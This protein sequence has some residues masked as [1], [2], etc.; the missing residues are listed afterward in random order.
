MCTNYLITSPPPTTNGDL[1]LGHLSG[2]YLHADIFAKAKQTLG[3]KVLHLSGTDDHQSY[4]VTKS[5]EEKRSI[6]ETIADY[7]REII[8]TLSLANINIDFF[9]DPMNN[10][11]IDFVQRFFLDLYQKGVFKEKNEWGYYCNTCDEYLFEAHIKGKCPNCTSFSGG[12]YCEACGRPNNPLDLINPLCT[13]C[14]NTPSKKKLTNL[15]F[16]LEDYRQLL[17]QYFNHNSWKYRKHLQDLINNMLTQPLPDV[18]ITN[19]YKWGIPVPLNSFK[20]YVLNVWFEMFPGHIN[21]L[22]EYNKNNS[23]NNK[24][25]SWLNK[26]KTNIIQFLGFDNSFYYVFLHQALALASNKYA[27]SDSFITNRFYLLEGQKFSTSRGHA[28]WAKEF[29][30]KEP[31]DIVRFYLCHTSPEEEENNFSEKEYNTFK[32]NIYTY[33][34]NIFDKLKNITNVN[35]QYHSSEKIKIR[36]I[37]N[38]EKKLKVLYGSINFSL[39][40]VSETLIAFLTDIN[41]L[42]TENLYKKDVG[43]IVKAISSFLY[44]VM[45]DLSKELAKVLNN[46]FT[47]DFF[48]PC[49]NIVSELDIERLNDLIKL[50]NQYRHSPITVL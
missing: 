35:D 38:Y 13:T 22:R 14:K 48:L 21:S 27:L 31:S 42:D 26:E 12:N 2:P 28:I 47:D 50:L 40:E 5:K 6:K 49:S 24:K 11:H 30:K 45:P 44:P 43:T 37:A 18:P 8:N 33:L 19:Y 4:V 25:F 41:S 46:N 15:F 1:H 7:R 17:Q 34:V 10:R 9:E 36:E 23:L 32:N 29:L 39:I 20:G 16:P 3:H